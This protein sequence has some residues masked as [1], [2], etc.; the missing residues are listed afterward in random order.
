MLLSTWFLHCT[1]FPSNRLFTFSLQYCFKTLLLS[2]CLMCF[3]LFL[4]T[5]NGKVWENFNSGKVA[6]LAYAEI[7]GKSALASYMQNP[8]P[9]KDEKHLFPEVSHH[10]DDGHDSNDQVV[11]LIQNLSSFHMQL[12]DLCPLIS[13]RIYGSYRNSLFQAFGT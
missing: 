12:C 2:L 4:Q 7:Q 1:L 9:M 10:N 6:S 5:F 3:C 13:P 8:S 11:Y